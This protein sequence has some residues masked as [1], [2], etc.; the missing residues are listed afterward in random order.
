MISSILQPSLAAASAHLAEEN[1]VTTATDF[2][3][4]RVEFAALRS[5]C[6]VYDLA[7]R[8]KL[9]LT[10]SDRTRWLNGML[11]NN[12]RDLAESQGT[13]AYLLNPQGHIQADLI[14]Y[15]RGDSIVVDS[16]ANQSTRLREI[17]DHY[18]IMDDV[19]LADAS[20][21]IT[22][23]GLQGPSTGEI[24]AAVGIHPSP[25]R[26]LELIDLKWNDF[27]ITFARAEE[28]KRSAYE[29]WIEHLLAPSLWEA[30]V[31][32]G[33]TPVGTQAQRWYRM[34][35]LIPRYGDD[36]RERDLPQETAQDQRALHFAKGCYVGQEIVERIHS[37]GQVHRTFTGF[38]VE[39]PPP[40]PGTKIS[41]D[42]KEVGEITS[43][44][45]IPADNETATIALGYIRR[46]AMSKPL[47]VDGVA[48]KAHPTPF[49]ELLK[50]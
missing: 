34:A 44:A 37:R 15:N 36:I 48:L 22:A 10:G 50:A 27:P 43:S 21:P 41:A 20:E 8:A 14:A 32:A 16:D 30:L 38:A 31:K 33:A 1:G 29:I 9:L 19:E 13:Y 28:W 46:E 49:S 23:I 7:W 26:P 4:A 6:G 35:S 45:A 25:L 47:L 3:D 42:T 11:T 24:L 2:G 40:A 12:V 39:G 5:G 17:F 18:I